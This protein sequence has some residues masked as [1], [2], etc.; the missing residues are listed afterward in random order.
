MK[1]LI[2]TKILSMALALALV[3]MLVWLPLGAALATNIVFTPD[4]APTVDS[5][6]SNDKG[7]MPDKVTKFTDSWKHTVIMTESHWGYEY[8]T[9]VLPKLFTVTFNTNGGEHDGGG[10]LAQE[11]IEGEAAV[12]PIVSR[13]GYRFDGWDKDFSNIT[14]QITVTAQWTQTGD[15][16]DAP[17]VDTQPSTDDNDTMP[18]LVA[19]PWEDPY[20]DVPET[21]WFYA[22]VKFV[23]ENAIMNGT[24]DGKFSPNVTMSRAMLVTVLYRLEGK[25]DVN[26]DITFPDV[27]AGQWYSDAILWA[28]ENGIVDGYENGKFG[29]D[30]PVTREQAV[31]ILYRYAKAKGLDVSASADLSGYTDMDDI[32]SWALDAMKWA[33]AVRIIEG[34]TS[35]TT[36][37]Q[38]TSTRA[39]VATIFMR[40]IE[41]FLGNVDDPEE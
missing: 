24:G 10:D 39:E 28:S 16:I 30:D 27:N 3:M 31:A 41:G 18:P 12:E 15:N 2:W 37:P 35:T 13:D 9:N 40:F 17:P 38:G 34:R 21:A 29:L 20:S 25:P 8:A 19:E 33:V 14:E 5:G 22:A 1:R 7:F 4:V 36:A 26:G 32:S 6:S 11:V 23:T